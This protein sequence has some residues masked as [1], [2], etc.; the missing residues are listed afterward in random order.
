M[1]LSMVEIYVDMLLVS[2]ARRDQ[3]NSVVVNQNRISQLGE[4]GWKQG[5]LMGILNHRKFGRILPKVGFLAN[6]RPKSPGFCV[7]PFY[8]KSRI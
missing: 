7:R 1:L 8:P 5:G 4:V 6:P 2:H 3:L